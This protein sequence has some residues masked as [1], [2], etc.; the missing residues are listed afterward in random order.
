MSRNLIAA[1]AKPVRAIAAVIALGA[2]L[3][4]AAQ[5]QQVLVMSEEQILTQSAAGQHI[6]TEIQRIRDDASVTLNERTQ[7]LTAESEALNA[8][9]SALSEAAMQQ[10]Q[11]LQERF[12][13]M[14][15]EGVELE[16][17]RAILRQELIATQNAAIEP[18][19]TALQAVLQ[20]IVDERNAS[21]LVERGQVV[22][23]AES[24]NITQDAIQRL[25]ARISE[26]AVSRVRL[27]D[28]QRAAVRQQVVQQFVAQQRRL[29]QLQAQQAAAQQQQ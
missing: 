23:A 9:T 14:A 26:P 1:V 15:N 20:E 25:N 28:E 29:Q 2:G 11:D 12:Q 13:N 8:E 24:A 3:T 5:A 17:E 16:V 7:A 22:Y 10:R 21:V 6:A 4:G 19:V 18:V 27:N